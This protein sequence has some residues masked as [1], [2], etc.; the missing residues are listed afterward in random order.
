VTDIDPD[1]PR[2]AVAEGNA[3]EAP[4]GGDPRAR[5][6]HERAHL[7]GQLGDLGRGEGSLAFDD[8]FAD[9]GQVAAEQGENRVLA[10]QLREQ[11]D[12]VERAL[13]KLDD[14]TYGQCEVCG[15]A[16]GESRLEAMP[17]ARFCIDHAG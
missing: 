4:D 5:L 2:D 9:S 12:D 17:A 15:A 16:I 8:N 3:F 6:E 1:A 14:G 11:L 13:T 7:E 10:T